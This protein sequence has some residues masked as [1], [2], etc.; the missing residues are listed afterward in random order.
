MQHAMRM[1][2]SY[3]RANLQKP[4]QPLAKRQ[5]GVDAVPVQRRPVDELHR[6]PRSTLGRASTVEQTRDVRM[7]EVGQGLAF[8]P[9]QCL[10]GAVALSGLHPLECDALFVFAIVALGQIHHGHAAP[11]QFADHPEASDRIASLQFRRGLVF[12]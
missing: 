5:R 8:A 10:A 7:V 1:R 11:T 9:E 2:E 6:K 3:C 12:A 4:F